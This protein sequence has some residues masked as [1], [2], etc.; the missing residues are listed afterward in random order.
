MPQD[1]KGLVREYWEIQPHWIDA[2]DE[3]GDEAGYMAYSVVYN[4]G[5]LKFTEHTFRSYPAAET[6]LALMQARSRPWGTG[7]SSF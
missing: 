6:C 5:F 4:G 2:E 3:D 1:Y 7:K